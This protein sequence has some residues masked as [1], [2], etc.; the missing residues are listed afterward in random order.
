MRWSAAQS[1]GWDDR[2]R[3]EDHLNS[4]PGRPNPIG[5]ADLF[6][7]MQPFANQMEIDWR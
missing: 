1:A 6:K 4:Y 7:D 3:Q 2:A 5:P